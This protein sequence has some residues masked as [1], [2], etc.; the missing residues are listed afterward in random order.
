MWD[1]ERVMCTST[2]LIGKGLKLNSRGSVSN[3]PPKIQKTVPFRDG[4]KRS[5]NDQ[6]LLLHRLLVTVNF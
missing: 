4:G 5:E 2:Q 6:Q 3:I 1:R